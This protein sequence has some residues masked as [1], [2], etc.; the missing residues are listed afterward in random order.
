MVVKRIVPKE[1]ST[2]LIVRLNRLYK[3]ELWKFVAITD[4]KN[5]ILYVNHS[6]PQK[7]IEGFL[8]V[9]TFPD[10]VIA[11]YESKTGVFL[12]YVYKKYG[13]STYRILIDSHL[14][15]MEQQEK[16]RA[17]EIAKAIIPL[18]KKEV[19]SENPIVK[20]DEYLA[21][22]IWKYGY[23]LNRS[24][25]EKTS[26]YG[27]VY[28]FY[29]GYLM[30]AGILKGGTVRNEDERQGNSMKDERKLKEVCYY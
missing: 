7:D 14:R 2:D 13:F 18:I 5:E 1:L 11:D 12:E 21:Y 10:Y 24:T 4:Q 9:I 8:E 23:D 27:N 28:E 19:D 16:A 6:I 26:N 20:Y 15:S 29:F 3:I 25:P 17:K 22:E 30:G